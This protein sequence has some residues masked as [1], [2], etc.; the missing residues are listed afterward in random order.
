[1]KRKQPNILFIMADELAPQ[2]LPFHGHPVVKAPHLTELAGKGVVFDAAYANAPLCAPSRAS[3][4]TG[5][6]VPAIG[7][8][9]NG[10]ELA[11]ELP[12][13][14]HYLR[15]QGYTTALSGKMHFI[16][17]DQLHGFERRLTTD[18]YPA[19]FSWSSNWSRPATAPNVAG[20]SMRPVLEAGPCLSNM[21]IEYDQEVQ[22]AARQYLIDH[23]RK[24]ED[25]KPFFLTVSF[26]QPHPPFVAQQEHWDR[27]DGVAIDLPRVPA[28]APE[29][30]D[31]QALALYYNHRRNLM[32]IG[33]SDL[34]A[35][36]RA[37]YGMVSW[38]DDRV[39][40]LME[41]LRATGMD[42]DTVVVFTSD[43]GEMLGERGMWL[44][45][46]MYEWSVRVPLI[47]AWPGTL[48]PRR[49]AA[50]VS[51]VDL[52]P[53][54]MDLGTTPGVPPAEPVESI[55]GH[56]LRTLL[57]QGSDAQWKDIAI[58]DY[59]A[60]PMPSPLRMVKRGQWKFIHMATQAPMLFD[61][62][63]DPDELDDRSADPACAG[64]LAELAQIAYAG[65]DPAAID[66][67]ARL[68]QRRRLLIRGVNDTTDS[69][70]DWNWHVRA[71]DDMRY[72]RGYG[73]RDGEHPTKAR[74]R[75]PYVEAADD[76]SGDQAN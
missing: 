2:V 27:Y 74:A 13:I 19:D 38:I 21:Q 72:V 39:G 3:M 22:F 12:T 48:G 31:P 24:G 28:L 71:D 44:K 4:L 33:Q 34:I 67:S 9:D 76:H 56:S 68:S 23:V 30:L 10:S 18:I 20:L 46:C 6:L 52:L 37:Y 40:E 57:Q 16:G 73:M 60:G 64:I 70:S 45:M 53:T 15:A 17:A 14:A 26:T 5:R 1:M 75:F 25:A 66:Q 47:I 29:R 32:P 49:V 11:S 41:T 69:R 36:R 54:L 43:H 50:N 63:S 55:D 59:G 58:S 35:A 65:Y 51:L 42:Q 7:I 61:L 62:S 8:W